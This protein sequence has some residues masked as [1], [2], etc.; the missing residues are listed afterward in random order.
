MPPLRWAKPFLRDSLSSA[1]LLRLVFKV[2]RD[3]ALSCLSVPNCRTFQAGLLTSLLHAFALAV[4]PPTSLPSLQ[5]I[6]GP[7][8]P[9]AGREGKACEVLPGSLSSFQGTI[10]S[11]LKPLL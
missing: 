3:L 10:A 7:G 2:L 5:L 8:F 11:G 4:L 1:E 9:K 6:P